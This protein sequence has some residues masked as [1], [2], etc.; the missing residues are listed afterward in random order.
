MGMR[1]SSRGGSA[2][3]A[4]QIVRKDSVEVENDTGKLQQEG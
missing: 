4:A 3:R 2:C 1:R